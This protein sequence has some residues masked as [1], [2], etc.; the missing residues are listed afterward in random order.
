MSVDKV[1][2][3]LV[4]L[5]T[6]AS[7]EPDDVGRYLKEFLSDP[8]VI[9]IAAPLRWLLVNVLIVPR[10]QHASAKLY[11]KVWTP[12]G[13]PLLVFSRE[14]TK[15]VRQIC[16]ATFGDSVVVELGMRYGNPSL[17]HAIATLMAHGVKS[18]KVLPLYPQFSLAAT[19]TAID[20]V[21]QVVRQ[22]KFAGTVTFF[23]A[24]YNH[25]L[26]LDAVAQVSAPHLRKPWDKVL[27]S[28]HGLP[29]RQVRKTDA[30]GKHCLQYENCCDAVVAA[31]ANCYRAQS[32]ATARSLATKL[33]LTK[34]QYLVG[35]QSR[36][37]RTPWI[38]P[39]SD[40]FYRQL[41]AQGVKRLAVLSPSFVADCLETLEEIS[42]RG[43][44]E[45][46]EH[47]GED[48]FLVP[49][50]NGSAVWAETVVKMMTPLL[51]NS[52]L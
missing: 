41:P 37:G 2:L 16:A 9:D 20:K 28:F 4:N 32:Y 36:L 19:Q 38:R 51:H 24:F 7:P 42:I 3:L 49:S 10:R 8:Y 33:G 12:E 35:F 22:R 50:L 46:R 52:T 14:H 23:P 15:K 11:K 30:T 25:D 40:E 44:E 17:D 39:H 43:L 27:F 18:I 47:G 6:P 29:E 48:L 45:F 13:S 5:G 21:N 26:Y 31:N 1:G 34:E